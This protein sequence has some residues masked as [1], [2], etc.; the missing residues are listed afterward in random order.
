MD[1]DSGK[2][3]TV[4]QTGELWLRGPS[5]MKGTIL[6]ILYIPFTFSMVVK[7]GNIPLAFSMVCLFVVGI[8]LHY[9]QYELE[10]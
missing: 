6:I 1:P 10:K 9:V 2:A 3:L 5:I 7:R 8:F 4:N